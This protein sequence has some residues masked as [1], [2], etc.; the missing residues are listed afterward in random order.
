MKTCIAISLILILLAGGT[1]HAAY[2]FDDATLVQPWKGG[3]VYGSGGWVDIVGGPVFDTKRITVDLRDDDVTIRIY[4]NYPRSGISVNGT[5]VPMADMAIDLDGNG[6]YEK[7]IVLSP[8][9]GLRTGLYD[10][11]RWRT[12][13]DIWRRTS[14]A[15]YGGLFDEGNPQKPDTRISRGNR[16]SPADVTVT[17]R[18][19]ISD[20]L[21]TIVLN[22]V[23]PDGSWDHLRFLFGTGTCGNDVIIGAIPKDTGGNPVPIPAA[24][25]LLGSGLVGLVAI[26]RRF[27]K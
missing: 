21:M 25:W 26:R 5:R 1:A 6:T 4:T 12:S 15:V 3:S 20:Y 27:K 14:W 17:G 18:N 13:D 24:A 9:N 10:V 11:T 8:H 16:V 22:N 23:N 2:T 7:G 19:E